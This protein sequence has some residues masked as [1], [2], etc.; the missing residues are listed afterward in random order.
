MYDKTHYKTKQNKTKKTHRAG[1]KILCCFFY[2]FM[3]SCM[4]LCMSLFRKAR[5]YFLTMPQGLWDLSS[6]TRDWPGPLTVKTQSPNHWTAREVPRKPKTFNFQHELH[7]HEDRAIR[8]TPTHQPKKPSLSRSPRAF[9][10]QRWKGGK[11]SEW[12]VR[13]RSRGP[14]FLPSP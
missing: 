5:N 8:H 14:A 13:L 2:L 10:S 6:L 9:C 7:G 12:R 4:Y 3:Y 1:K 11:V